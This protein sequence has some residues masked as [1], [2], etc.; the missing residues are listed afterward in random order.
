MFI[1]SSMFQMRFFILLSFFICL[2]LLETRGQITQSPLTIEAK[3][4]G[5]TRYNDKIPTPDQVLGYTIGERHTTPS[6]A[7]RYFEAVANVS[8]RVTLKY[9]GRTAGGRQLIHAVVSKSAWQSEI[10]AIK[11]EHQKL[12]TDPASVNISNMPAVAYMGYSIHGNEAS[13]TEAALLTLYHFA[14][15][16]GPAIDEV[17]DN[18]VILIDPLLNPDGRNRFVDWVNENKGP[19]YVNDPQDREHRE[20]WPNG[21]T[22]HYW[23]DL[24]RDWLPLQ[25]PESQ[26]RIGLF[27]EWQ[28]QVLTDFH[29]MGS[30]ATYFF[31]PGI[32][33][34]TNPLTSKLNQQLTGDIAAFNAAALDNIGSLYFTR[35]SYDD[36][37]YGKGSTYPD[38]NGAV[39]ILF[40]Q[41]SS[42]ALSRA[43]NGSVLNYDFTI[44]NQYIASLA[45]LK[46]IALNKNKLLTYTRDFYQN[47]SKIAGKMPKG[48][49]IPLKD[50]QDRAV[51]F[52]TLLKRH[53]IEVYKDGDNLIIPSSQNQIK[54]LHT[55]MTTN[56]QFQDSL[57]YD[58]STWTLPLAFDLKVEQLNKVATKDLKVFDE[59]QLKTGQ[60][61]GFSNETYAF[62]LP[63]N[64]YVAA[65]ALYQLQAAGVRVRLTN[66][67]FVAQV[68][69]KEEQF[70]RGSII[71]P[72]K[73]NHLSPQQTIALVK[74]LSIKEKLDFYATNTGL[75]PAGPDLGG[76]STVVLHQPRVALLTGKGVTAYY[77]GEIRFVLN[78]K[79][80]I[81]VSLLDVESISGFDLSQ[82][83]HII[84]TGGSYSGLS[85]AKM[86]E[87]V[88]NGGTLIGTHTAS[89][90]LVNNTMISLEK[91]VLDMDA[92][93]KG[94]SYE[95]M[96]NAY[97]AQRI[98]GAIFKVNLDTTHPLCF[99]LNKTLP[100]FRKHESFYKVSGKPGITIGKYDAVAP[101]MS[102]YLSEN[103]LNQ[104]KGKAAI[105]ANN[106]GRG[107]VVF[108]ADNPVFR[109]FWRGSDRLLINS[110]FFD[111]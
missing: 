44:R 84:M 89:S 107:K 110:I 28:P 23:F 104:A 73:G 25:H 71:I 5:T 34:R 109:G 49:K 24:N 35:E 100:V 26:A 9:H 32:P 81:P 4:E 92:V 65:R 19:V 40:E 68:N 42:R 94:V 95:G 16:E 90:W 38:I 29:E 7:I 77:A 12:R 58:V 99:G 101:L 59:N 74:Q 3:W 102:G 13:G 105:C 31:Q 8:D 67:D 52:A 45:T 70:K 98:G 62:I 83:T 72:V 60:L 30:D 48:Y 55:I 18:V 86:R 33:S 10:E 11:K 103:R 20:P 46:G 97:G 96:S 75:T 53:Q 76:R 63:W 1:I 91:E 69:D 47:A 27:Y 57:F 66:H 14:A 51:E 37:Y 85:A 93:L 2:C 54:L 22:N 61:I 6:D 17:L 41:A 82:Y 87:F 106:V 64:R 50:Q 39:G 78:E 21:R 36:F 43:V 111:W 80:G 79:L 108:I 56:K 15:G 88:V